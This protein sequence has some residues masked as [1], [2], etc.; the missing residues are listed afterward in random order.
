MALEALMILSI[1]STA[2]I[3][4]ETGSLEPEW[5]DR[6]HAN[7]DEDSK[8]LAQSSRALAGYL[9]GDRNREEED[10][11][12][13]QDEI[14]ALFAGRGYEFAELE[15]EGG[16][17]VDQVLKGS[18]L[19][20]DAQDMARVPLHIYAEDAVHLPLERLRA[21]LQ[22]SDPTEEPLV[23]AQALSVPVGILMR[24]L[25]CLPELDTGYVLCDRAGS[26]IW[27]K[28]IVGFSLPRIGSACPLWPIF[29]SLSQPGT[30][31]R[32]DV[33]QS[34]RQPVPFTVFATAENATAPG[35]NA[36]PLLRA[37]MLLRPGDI[38][39]HAVEMGSSCRLCARATCPARREPSVLVSRP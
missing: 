29:A 1:R 8:R 2:S 10:A 6:F 9:E 39:A 21:Y 26:L 17:T 11:Q 25:S 13:P 3:L 14:D 37:G 23:I 12:I 33:V 5:L 27:R 19:S 28:P 35:Y 22:Q 16:G 20:A 38:A 18:R 4:A 32:N 15:P 30:V 34:G 31:L 7:I 36:V 24:R